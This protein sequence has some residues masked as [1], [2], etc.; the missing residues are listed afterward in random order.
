VSG[1]LPGH[2]N[3]QL[4]WLLMCQS[5]RKAKAAATLSKNVEQES[6]AWMLI[7]SA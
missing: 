2:K 7:A 1:R 5:I 3:L 6:W 4:R